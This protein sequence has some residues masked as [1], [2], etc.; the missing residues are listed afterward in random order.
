MDQ[1]NEELDAHPVR[2]LDI[3]NVEAK[4]LIDEKV[5][6]EYISPSTNRYQH[7]LGVVQQ[8][9]QLVNRLNLEE[10]LKPLFIQSA[11][12]HD[13]GYSEKL[14]VHHFH[15][16]DGAIF[17]HQQDFPKPVVAAVLF[18]SGAYQS[19]KRTRPDLVPLY[20]YNGQWLDETDRLFIDLITY[21]DL[22]TSPLGKKIS[23]KERIDD[24]IQRYGEKHEVSQSM[25][26]NL[27]HFQQTV[28]RVEKLIAMKVNEKRDNL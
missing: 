25:I 4:S 22:H 17:A 5:L 13:I 24:I 2:L 7:I 3:R 12:L 28:Q 27:V 9:K 18:H 16:V 14:N 11:Y 1:K 19:V 6:A 20:S 21:C 8:M 26:E 10:R 15:P 23:V